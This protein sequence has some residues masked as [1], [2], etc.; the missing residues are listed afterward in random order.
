MICYS[1]KFLFNFAKFL[2]ATKL[3]TYTVPEHKLC[4]IIITY[5]SAA[6]QTHYLLP[7]TVSDTNDKYY[8][9]TVH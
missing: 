8:I 6:L 4:I 2:W 7:V 1:H 3:A 9:T 5:I